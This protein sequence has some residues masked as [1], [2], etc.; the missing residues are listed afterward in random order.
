[1]YDRLRA[2]EY[3]Q[4]GPIKPRVAL[5]PDIHLVLDDGH[6]PKNLHA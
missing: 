1:M 2:V 6:S 5:G 3:F 4:L